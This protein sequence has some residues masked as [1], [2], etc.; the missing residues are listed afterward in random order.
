MKYLKLILACLFLASTP[1]MLSACDKNS[2][3]EEAAEEVSD[4]IDDATTN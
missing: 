3:L 1:L 4:E 2:D